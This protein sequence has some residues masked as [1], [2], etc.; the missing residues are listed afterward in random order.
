MIYDNAQPNVFL[1]GTA[2]PILFRNKIFD[3]KQSGLCFKEKARGVI[4]ENEIYGNAFSNVKISGSATPILRFNK[5]FNGKQSG[6]WIKDNSCPSVFKNI[7]YGNQRVDI[8]T[9]DLLTSFPNL[10]QNQ[11]E[12]KEILI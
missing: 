1:F 12:E 11:I 7:F 3:G 4:E 8:L 6:L 10:E 9:S 2:N 5:I